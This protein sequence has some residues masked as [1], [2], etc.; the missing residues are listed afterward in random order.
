MQ[1]GGPEGSSESVQRPFLDYFSSIVSRKTPTGVP[2]PDSFA[3]AR[4][5]ADND[6]VME[7]VYWPEIPNSVIAEAE[8]LQ[9]VI[10]TAAL[11]EAFVSS[12]PH[13]EQGAYLQGTVVVHHSAG[14]WSRG[15]SCLVSYDVSLGNRTVHFNR[16]AIEV[17]MPQEGES[18]FPGPTTKDR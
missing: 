12:L 18:A 6:V 17:R 14:T 2:I 10:A 1:G 15:F 13:D 8:A 11:R 9:S 16:Q 5:N 3:W 7:S 4:L